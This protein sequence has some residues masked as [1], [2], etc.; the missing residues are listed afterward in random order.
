MDK[1][2]AGRFQM[3]AG[4]CYKRRFLEIRLSIFLGE[5][6][7]ILSEGSKKLNL[8]PEN[9]DLKKNI[10]VKQYDQLSWR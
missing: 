4:D 7:E 5:S 8:L 6:N 2:K 9:F 1:F 3:K 10:R